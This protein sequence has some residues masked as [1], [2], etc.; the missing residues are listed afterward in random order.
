VCVGHDQSFDPVWQECRQLY[1]RGDLGRIVH[2]DSVMAY[3]LT[4]PFGT[5]LA[6]EPDHWV[7]RLPGGLFQNT[8]SHPLYKITD[9]LPDEQ[10]RVWATWMG[11]TPPGGYPTELRVLLQGA[12]TTGSLLFTSAARPLQRVVRLYGTRQCVEVDFDARLLRRYRKTALPGPFGKIEMPARH[13]K[14]AARSLTRNLWRF[15]RSD[16]HYFAGMKQL[17]EAFYRAILDG[18]E[19]PIPYGE[20]L[21]VTAIMDKIFQCCQSG[22]NVPQELSEQEGVDGVPTE[23]TLQVDRTL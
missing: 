5:V 9:F 21:R 19:P 3:D 23:S 12:E 2:V 15:L 22:A 8:I 4:G 7:H 1:R 17:F 18:R 16:L 6:T 14:E 20:I 10:L 11:S 13:L